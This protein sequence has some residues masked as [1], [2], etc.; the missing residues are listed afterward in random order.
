MSREIVGKH[1]STCCARCKREFVCNP[2]NISN[3]NCNKIELSH[4]E[5][6]YIA[7]QFNDCVCNA[8]LT[9]LKFEFYLKFHHNKTGS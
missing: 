3:C 7:G 9:E 8:C 1:E 6:Q 2:F 5:T 4:E